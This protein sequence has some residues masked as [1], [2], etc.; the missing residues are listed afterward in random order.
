MSVVNNYILVFPLQFGH[1][2][3]RMREV[4]DFIKE[5]YQD[6]ELGPAH[7]WFCA[8]RFHENGMCP[9]METG[10]KGFEHEVR[11]GAFNGTPLE[12][13]EDAIRSAKWCFPEDVRLFYC[14]DD[15]DHFSL[16]D[17]RL[18]PNER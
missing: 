5:Y 15:D 18:P 9:H 14:L 17:L 16:S 12:V 6:D 1:A 3:F 8:E 4:N 11:L 7:G 10:S 13:V 2:E